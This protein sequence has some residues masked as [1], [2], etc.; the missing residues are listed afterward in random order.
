LKY[1]GFEFYTVFDADNLDEVLLFVYEVDRDELIRNKKIQEIKMNML[2]YF[3][4]IFS[5]ERKEEKRRKRN[6]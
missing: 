6:G 5:F 2:Q 4:E 3:D 1:E